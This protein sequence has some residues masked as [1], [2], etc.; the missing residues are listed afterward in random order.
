MLFTIGETS[1]DRR[2]FCVESEQGHVVAISSTRNGAEELL[3]AINA[4]P[5]DRQEL[6]AAK[7]AILTKDTF[8][9]SLSPCSS[10]SIIS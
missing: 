4:I 3:S 5:E 8:I 6:L 10:G 2:M 7:A 9:H 1:P